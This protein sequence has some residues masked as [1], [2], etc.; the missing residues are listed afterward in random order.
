MNCDVYMHTMI[1]FFLSP[2]SFYL[3]SFRCRGLFLHVI[4]HCHTTTDG[5]TP[6]DEGS[7]RCRDLYLTTHNT[8][9]RKTSGGIRTRDPSRL[10]PEDPRLR[11]LVYWDHLYDIY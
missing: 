10:P 5:R 2:T 4:T 9:N 8:D 6:L 11:P 1:F 7:A 3:T